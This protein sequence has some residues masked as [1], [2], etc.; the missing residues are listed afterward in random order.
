MFSNKV[1]LED[2]LDDTPQVLINLLF[3]IFFIK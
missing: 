1:H 3:I 2:A